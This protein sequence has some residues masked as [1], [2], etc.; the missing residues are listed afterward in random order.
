MK[1]CKEF[2]YYA[3]HLM[4]LAAAMFDDQITVQ[5]YSYYM[6]VMKNAGNKRIRA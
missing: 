4:Q 3:D 5:E 1:N 6:G 2:F